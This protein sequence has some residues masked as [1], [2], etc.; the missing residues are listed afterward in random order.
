MGRAPLYT[1]PNGLRRND[2]GLRTFAELSDTCKGS[3]PGMQ[4]YCAAGGT[5]TAG[6]GAAGAAA[7]TG[8]WIG[9]AGAAA[10]ST[11]PMASLV[12]PRAATAS[13]LSAVIFIWSSSSAIRVRFYG[14]GVGVGAA[15]LA[16]ACPTR[17]S[18]RPAMESTGTCTVKF[19]GCSV[20][21]PFLIE[22]IR[23]RGALPGGSG[24][25]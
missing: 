12:W 11:W 2:K 25:A 3:A 7:A 18:T 22:T 10:S 8:G 17:K 13:P 1:A 5:G 19:T 20:A 14:A 24:A 23:R 4:S 6:T 16:W 9:A 15:A 21:I